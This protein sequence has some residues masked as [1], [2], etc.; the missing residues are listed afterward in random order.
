[1]LRLNILLNLNCC[2]QEWHSCNPNSNS[3]WL[4]LF[5]VQSLF[6]GL[7]LTEVTADAYRVPDE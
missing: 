7:W 5:H 4:L 3:Q 1:M 2:V 6:P